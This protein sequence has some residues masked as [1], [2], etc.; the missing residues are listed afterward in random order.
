MAGGPD[1]DLRYWLL[2][3]MPGMFEMILI[4]HTPESLTDWHRRFIELFEGCTRRAIR[5]TTSKPAAPMVRYLPVGKA[6]EAHPMALPSDK[7]E[8]V[9]DRFEMFGIGQCQC[10]MAMAS[11]GHGCGKPLGNCTVMGQW[12][13]RGIEDGWLQRSRRRTPWR[14]NARPKSTAWS[15]G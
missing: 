9:L 5:W 2:P 10:R 14:S 13:E 3:I 12:A 6:I 1:E 4:C 11:L 15:T 7:L 8:I